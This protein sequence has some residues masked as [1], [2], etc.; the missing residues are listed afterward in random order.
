MTKTVSKAGIAM[1]MGLSVLLL[2]GCGKSSSKGATAEPQKEVFKISSK[3]LFDKYAQNEV[4]MDEMMKGKLVQING[5]IQ[6]VDKDP[7]DN[8]VIAL[9]T[10]N[11]FMPS[12]LT[13]KDSEKSK[14]ISA[15]KGSKVVL[16]CK[17]M[18]RLIG[19]PNGKDCE[20]VQ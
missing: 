11:Q 6:S 8:I 10:S 5:T 14:A 4:A 2:A 15:K 20:F 3:Q 18:S 13:L 17:K 12:R 19:S 16:Q 9:R 1:V 7:F